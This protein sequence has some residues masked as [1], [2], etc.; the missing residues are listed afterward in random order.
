MIKTSFIFLLTAFLTLGALAAQ[1]QEGCLGAAV[2]DM[3]ITST[4]P[5]DIIITRIE[6]SSL[7]ETFGEDTEATFT[8]R[9]F[10]DLSQVSE[11]A[12]VDYPNA[13][14]G[15]LSNTQTLTFSLPASVFNGVNQTTVLDLHVNINEASGC[16][17][18]E[19]IAAEVTTN[20]NVD[21][22]CPV[23]ISSSIYSSNCGIGIPTECGDIIVST[24]LA[25]DILPYLILT[26]QSQSTGVAPPLR[27]EILMTISPAFNPDE[28]SCAGF[29]CTIST[30]DNMVRI[31]VHNP[32]QSLELVRLFFQFQNGGGSTYC[33]TATIESTTFFFANG[34]ECT[35]DVAES[36]GTDP[37][38]CLDFPAN[39]C[40]DINVSLSS[41]DP[42][43][44]ELVLTQTGQDASAIQP[45]RAD[46]ILEVSPEV[47][48]NAID[49][50]TPNCSV[51]VE[52]DVVR[53]IVENPPANQELASIILPFPDGGSNIHCWTAEVVS[54]S[55]TYPVGD[56]CILDNFDSVGNDEADCT[57]FPPN[58]CGGIRADFTLN[59]S[60]STIALVS[61]DQNFNTA[62]PIR[63]EVF[64]TLSSDGNLGPIT[65]PASNCTVSAEGNN[66]SVV[67]ENP[68]TDAE[69]ARLLFSFP[70]NDGTISCWL[71]SVESVTYFYAQG[72]SCVFTDI[73]MFGN[74]DY[75]N[76]NGNISTLLYSRYVRRL[77]LS[78]SNS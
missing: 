9:F 42:S 68:P 22:S 12:I 43:S 66:I 8:L 60:I 59:Q 28:I 11:I 17:G 30:E 73:G 13:E 62:P 10:G 33:W 49:C 48:L 15:P 61:E 16:L 45:L 7:V 71:A 58:V 74:G 65:C 1:A 78:P 56:D 21:D 50:G 44:P 53:V 19:L 69:I 4:A 72:P 46:I 35:I 6:V 76:V 29:D 5:G 2:Q 52:D 25:S 37:S 26:Q 3:N 70:E 41:T 40:G 64:L 75:L 24:D 32:S 39:T 36:G 57:P 18:V 55:F 54:V 34:A 63:A 31:I 14:I 51:I 38:D 77:N 23:D 20:G 67:I 27:A 47:D